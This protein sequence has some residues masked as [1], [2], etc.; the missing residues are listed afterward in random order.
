[1]GY[2]DLTGNI[3]LV[4]PQ[5]GLFVQA[6]GA[7]EN[8]FST[9]RDRK[10]LRGAKAGRLV[11]AL[12]D[13][14]PPM[15]LRSLAKRAGIDAGYASRLVDFLD[16][17]ALIT[18]DPRGAIAASRWQD[19][20]RRWAQAYSPLER[21]RVIWYLAPRGLPAIL[22]RLKNL[23]ARYAISGSW[24]ASQLAPVAATRLI[25]CYSDDREG[26]ARMLDL[27]LT[28]TG[29][30]VALATPF[31]PVVYDRTLSRDGI[32]IAAPSQIAA[33][34][35]NTPGRGPNESDALMEWME[36]NE[37]VWRH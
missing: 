10:S 28:D 8:P 9:R 19:L 23:S 12:C 20:I 33:D 15:G 1:M 2:A 36:A 30:N 32:T 17:E 37:S 3:R 35:L 6:T 25:L 21:E 31:D 13:F 24:A 22:N 34:L 14:R 27:R 18:R 26:L 29:A 7:T 4:L 5:P 11:R 16:R